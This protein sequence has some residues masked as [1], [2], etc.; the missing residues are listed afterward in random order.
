MKCVNCD[1]NSK[2]RSLLLKVINYLRDDNKVLWDA[3]LNH[4]SASR[5]ESWATNKEVIINRLI[6]E[7]VEDFKR[8]RDEIDVGHLLHM[9]KNDIKS[10]S[11]DC[12]QG[13]EREKFAD[14][15]NKKLGIKS[16]SNTKV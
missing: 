15:W 14:D 6:A 10:L 8:E 13:R 1:K 4:G 12:K 5:L 2:H 7:A 9:C 11:D 16:R 3:I